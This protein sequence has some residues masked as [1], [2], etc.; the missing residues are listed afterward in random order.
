MIR[1][2]L[3]RL[4]LVA[5]LIVIGLSMEY[6][7]LLDAASIID[8][9]RDYARHWWLVVV[10]IL[11]QALLF[12]F[13][14]AGS[15]FLWVAATLYAPP[16]ATFIL[17]AGGTLG[18]LG[19]YFFSGFL[20]E[21]WKRRIENS[22]SYRLMQ[23]QDNF[24]TLFAMR[25]F[26]GFPHSLVNYSAGILRANLMHFIVAAIL[27]I[28]IKSFIYARVIY[29][30]ASSLSLD[31]LLDFTILGPLV[32]LSLMSVVAVWINYRAGQKR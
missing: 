22:R 10:L 2:H 24:F 1:R 23:A 31:L 5:V 32:L 21:D 6:A 12:T 17:A 29:G 26:P 16:M 15:L 3:F 20:T 4:I 7:G 28:S 14:L 8:L 30:A 27:G 11:A 9:A 19:A 13:A 18:G 25:V